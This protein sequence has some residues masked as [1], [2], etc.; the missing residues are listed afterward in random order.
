[1]PFDWL[2]IISVIFALGFVLFLAYF[3]VRL[4]GRA[5]F[6]RSGN[7]KIIEAVS[8][9]PQ[10][11]MQ[12]IKA[13]DKYFLIGVSRTGI[14]LIGEVNADSI[15]INEALHEMPFEKYLNNF[16]SRKKKDDDGGEN[17]E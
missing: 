5:R 1:M 13:G 16:I 10:S 14:T 6:S 15:N 2:N 4:M 17:G 9:S 3:S 7:I 8:V 12:L 11:S